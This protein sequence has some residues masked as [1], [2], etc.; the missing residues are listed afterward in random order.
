LEP[1]LTVLERHYFDPA[2]QQL[3]PREGAVLQLAADGLSGPAI[4]ER[5]GVSCGTVRIHFGHIYIKLEVG[6]RGGAV[7]KGMRLG[8]IS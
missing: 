2:Q 3:T 5:L 4:A 1:G 8:M 6:G 7:A